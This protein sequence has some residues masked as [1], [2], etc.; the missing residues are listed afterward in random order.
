MFFIERIFLRIAVFEVCNPLSVEVVALGLAQQLG[1]VVVA[2]HTLQPLKHPQV[3]LLDLIQ[4]FH[5]LIMI[6]TGLHFV[7]GVVELVFARRLQVP[8]FCCRSYRS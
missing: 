3:L 2:F 5:T 8:L 7:G 1:R 4:T 6:Q